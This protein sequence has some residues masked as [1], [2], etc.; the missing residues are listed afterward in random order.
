M[1]FG[2][3]RGLYRMKVRQL[4]SKRSVMVA[5]AIMVLFGMSL[6]VNA[7][8]VFVKYRGPVDLK[9]FDCSFTSS[10]F[11]HRICYND[12]SQYIVVLLNQTYYHYCRVPQSVVNQ[13]LDSDSKGRF[14]NTDVKGKYDCRLGGVPSENP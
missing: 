12:E 5:L 11:V 13:W 7:E 10:S 9:G 3:L 4:I 14:F 6:P 1:V 8:T 2:T